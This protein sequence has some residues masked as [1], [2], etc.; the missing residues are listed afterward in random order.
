VGAFF[1]QSGCF[2]AP[3]VLRVAPDGVAAALAERRTNPDKVVVIVVREL[4]PTL[5]IGASVALVEGATEVKLEVSE[6]IA[7][8][9]APRAFAVH[10]RSG[11]PGVVK[12]VASL[13]QDL[14]AALAAGLQ[15]A[16]P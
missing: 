16:I 3:A 4:G 10:W 1:A 2:S 7:A 15:P 11:G 9:P 13:P 12:G 6:Y 8:R 5:A 14:Q